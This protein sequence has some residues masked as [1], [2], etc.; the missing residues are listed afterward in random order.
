LAPPRQSKPVPLV[1]ALH[2]RGSSPSQFQS[3][4]F[5]QVADEYGFVVAYLDP[6]WP[7]WKDQ[8]NISYISSMISRLTA[9]ENIDPQRVYVA[10]FSLGGYATYRSAC[11]LSIQVA[12][13]AVVSNAMAPFSSK[14]CKISRPVSELEIAGSGDLF[15]VHRTSSSPISA[16]QTAA[17]WRMLDGCSAQSQTSRSQIGPV[18][19][20]TWSKCKAGSAVGE[21]IVQGGG[22]AWPGAPG[23]TG[24]DARYSAT[25]AIWSFFARHRAASAR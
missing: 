10:G 3:V 4:G 11:Q 14:P 23:Y 9:S 13:V 16:D 12:A 21:Y 7:T 22:H 8:S 24:A 2:G 20:T 18:V 15:P 19:E 1:I 5:N 25:R 6:S 17:D